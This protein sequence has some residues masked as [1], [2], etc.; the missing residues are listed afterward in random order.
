MDPNHN[1]QDITCDGMGHKGSQADP[2]NPPM[3]PNPC[4]MGICDG[5]DMGSPDTQPQPMGK[6]CSDSMGDTVCNATGTCVQCLTSADCTGANAGD[7]CN[8]QNQCVSASCSN[9][10]K[11]NG[12]T[13]IDCGGPN[14]PPCGD[15]KACL[16]N[17]DCVDKICA[18][19][20]C[21][22]PQCNDGVQNG[23][24]TDIDCG[25]GTCPPCGPGQKCVASTDCKGG[26]CGGTCIPNCN[27]GVQNNDETDVDCG[28]SCPM[29][30]PVGEK[31]NG[32][33]DCADSA[34][35]KN[36]NLCVASQCSDHRQDGSETDVD[37]G[38][39]SCPGCATGQNC[40]FDTD[41]AS[42][43]C[44]ALMKTCVMSQCA[45]HQK[46]GMETDV[47]CG[48]PNC[49]GCAL[50]KKCK[51]DS[52]C[53]SL[54]CSISS[55]TC[56]AQCADG[57]KDGNETDIDCGGGGSC[58]PCAVGKGCKANSDCTSS[59][60]DLVQMKCVSSTCVDERKDGTESDVD[61]G[62]SCPNGCAVGQL[63]NT[64]TDCA[65]LACDP[66]TG[67]CAAN[68]CSDQQKDGAETDV[69]C[70]GGQCPQCA[71]GMH[72]LGDNDCVAPNACDANSLL[73]V[74]NQCADHRMDG[75]ETDVDCGGPN[76]C[77]RCGS[78]KM[79]TV[80]SDCLSGHTCNGVTHTCS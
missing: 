57:Q 56:V 78:G 4:L 11:D 15:F 47:D 33:P 9:N 21:A 65:N 5:T 49:G 52:D 32:D 73:C 22:A 36:S 67:K 71:I 60:C 40:M 27:D 43:A 20:S 59:A 68:Q 31:C 38:G 42:S 1:C 6:P 66:M 77:A 10:I 28:G 26:Q 29:G 18:N 54:G 70:G 39:P 44:D 75:S 3:P 61:C 51:T 74:G 72:C 23:T 63:C 69:D 53:L 79:C 8:G 2:N 7:S 76:G 55:F 12:E 45:D 30:C 41:C 17:S 37:C 50:T 62:G 48:G 16:Q 34:C 14:C 80:T 25:G 19:N 24:E 46:D 58:S 13:D 64:D 35:D